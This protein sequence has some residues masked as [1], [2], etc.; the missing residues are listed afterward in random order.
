MLDKFRKDNPA[1]ANVPDDKLALGIYNKYYK[2]KMSISDF[3]ARVAGSPGQSEDEPT[4][5]KDEAMQI[6]L[7]KEERSGSNPQ[8]TED[9]V[10]DAESQIQ[11]S[12]QLFADPKD[13]ARGRKDSAFGRSRQPTPEE[14]GIAD[15]AQT[16]EPYTEAEATAQFNKTKAEDAVGI[17]GI[18]MVDPMMAITGPLGMPVRAAAGELI[19]K[20]LTVE[21]AETGLKKSATTFSNWLATKA[22]PTAVAQSGSQVGKQVAAS[23]IAEPLTGQIMEGVVDKTTES[24]LH[25]ALAIPLNLGVAMLTGTLAEGTLLKLEQMASKAFAGKATPTP[26]E[27]FK[28]MK[29]VKIDGV[30]VIKKESG[31]EE[32]ISAKVKVDSR[33]RNM[34]DMVK[35][36]TEIKKTRALS[37]EIDELPVPVKSAGQGEMSMSESAPKLYHG[38]SKDITKP[39]DL[40]KGHRGYFFTDAEE[41]AAKFGKVHEATLK[42]VK[43]FDGRN[44]EDASL[45][46][47]AYEDK[48]GPGKLTSRLQQVQSGNHAFYEDQRTTWL[49]EDLGFAGNWQKEDGAN[50]TRVFSRKSIDKI[51][52]SGQGSETLLG[53]G[54]GA[55][56]GVETDDEGNIIGYDIVRGSVGAAGGAAGGAQ[57][58]MFMSTR[59]SSIGGMGKKAIKDLKRQSVVLRDSGMTPQEVH[60]KT[61]MW[62]AEDGRWM[63]ELDDSQAS[64]LPSLIKQDG[65]STLD[66]VVTNHPKLYEYYPQ[67]GRLKIELMPKGTSKDILGGYSQGTDP[68]T[69][70]G[71]IYV[72][73]HSSHLEK[74]Q[75]ILHETQHAIQFIEGTTGGYS[76]T[77][78]KDLDMQFK[79]KITL[80]QDY[81]DNA[82]SGQNLKEAKK[83]LKQTIRARKR[84][85]VGESADEVE[86]FAAKAT[87][88]GLDEQKIKAKVMDLKDKGKVGTPEYEKLAKEHYK[89]SDALSDAQADHMLAR[90]KHNK[91]VDNAYER[92]LGERF[93]RSTVDRFMLSAELRAQSFP[94]FKDSLIPSQL[95]KFTSHEAAA[96]GGL[97]AIYN[98]VDWDE[99]EETG[100][101]KVDGMKMLRGALMGIAGVAGAKQLPKAADHWTKGTQKLI[102][103]PLKDLVNGSITNEAA[104]YQLGLGRSAEMQSLV[105]GYKNDASLVLKKAIHLGR[106]LNEAAPTRLAQKRLAQVLEGGTTTNPSLAKKAANINKMFAD[107]KEATRDL[108]LNQYSRFDKLSRR[109]RADLRNIINDPSRQM[110]EI[111][112]A[113]ELLNNYYHYGS[114]KE[115][116]PIFNPMVE[117]LTKADKKALQSEINHLKKQSRFMNPEGSQ[118]MEAHI[119]ELEIFLKE[120][121]KSKSKVDGVYL[122]RGYSNMRQDLPTETLNRFNEIVGTSYR[123]AKGAA[124]QGRDVLKAELLET[125][126]THPD[127][128]FP[129]VKGQRPPA[130]YIKLGG[131]FTEDGKKWGAL[132]GQYVRK[133][134]V[135]DL[136]EVIDFRSNVERNM[137]KIMSYWKYGK[138]ILNPATHARNAASN[139]VQAYFAGVNPADTHTYASAAK[140]LKQGR[141][142]VYF[143]EAE[144][145]GVYNNTFIESDISVLRDS[146]DSV[147]SDSDLGGWLRKALTLPATAYDQSERFFKTAVFI[148]AREK[149]MTINEAGEHTMKYMFN[150]QDIPPV[151]KHYKRWAAP[152]ITYS[153]KALPLVAE[154]AIT[155][156]WKIGAIYGA[157]YG[158]TTLAQN[159][160]GVSDETVDKDR[161]VMLGNQGPLQVLM[162]F[163]DDYGNRQ[164]LN[165]EFFMPW[166]GVTDSWGQS[167]V[168]LGS[169]MPSNPIASVMAGYYTNKDSFTGQEIQ[170]RI[171]DGFTTT[172]AKYA[173]YAWKQM[174]PSMAPGGHSMNKIVDGLKNELGGN[175]LDYAGRRKSIGDAALVTLLGIKLTPANQELFDRFTAGKLRGVQRAVT[176]DRG[177]IIRELERNELTQQ[178]AD[179]QMKALEDLQLSKAAE[180]LKHV[181]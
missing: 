151:V 158:A 114:A 29:S 177:R 18:P 79:N 107:L 23:V 40:T 162:P 120:G 30:D 178:E 31:A 48:Y 119:S 46:A 55:A 35:G 175:R 27:V 103:E 170:N 171:L 65:S 62:Q 72:N 181:K 4:T 1:Y 94:D 43:I 116:L 105:K 15:A 147:R 106:E 59:L 121:T 172:T 80:V 10:S 81:I 60:A 44:K 58:G 148:H 3:N 19:G 157:M 112:T 142:N 38:N 122:D 47:K 168:P 75:T 85:G 76:P 101:I 166:G 50:T 26:E 108:N 6:A 129:K 32:V 180:T 91:K 39:Q 126:K 12:G 125:V 24:G 153:Y 22:A 51:G 89:I 90:M 165:M 143:K 66:K 36:I 63:W 145:W 179:A 69:D 13:M 16:G 102:I 96:G 2:D 33:P 74:Q 86:T 113:Q 21:A 14:G 123:V 73:P 104:R 34:D 52:P 45:L 95:A 160:L 93:A 138:A 169:V 155:K 53:G 17:D 163:K 67:L 154:M 131:K 100:T 110:A 136:Q 128:V 78:I 20:A 61:G 97:G 37:P 57:L 71:T 83:E 77:R 41:T 25:P 132:N 68:I 150:Y 140:A 174:V 149:G 88:L 64:V 84:L 111:Q 82:A 135:D 115:Y 167:D 159:A 176:M 92:V 164:Y 28:W 173:E 118:N 42:D 8:S 99:Y 9:A 5:A 130:N 56:A 54:A 109:E 137:D 127:W 133:D 156:P 144:N 49:L 11:S 70:P 139:T 152:F 98:G 141:E 134:I 146:L 124:T 161:S 7:D 87:K 117:G